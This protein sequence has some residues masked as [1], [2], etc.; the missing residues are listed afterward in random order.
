MPKPFIDRQR[1][2][3]LM[4]KAGIDALLV[5]QPENFAYA[6]GGPPGIA[7]S[8]RR[9]GAAIAIVPAAAGAEPAAIVTDFGEGPF[10]RSAALR[11]VRTHTA[12]VD[13]VDVAAKLP[14]N[15][16]I[17]ELIAEVQP[18]R[19][20]GFHRP[21]TFD[22]RRALEL[23]RDA[24][25]ERGLAKARLGVEFDFLPVSDMRLIESVLPEA[26]LVDS[27]PVFDRLRMVKTPAE[28]DLLRKGA[29]LAEA[30]IRAVMAQIHVG[31]TRAEI[32][33]LWRATVL[34]EARRKGVAN[35]TGQWDYTAVGPDPWSPHGVVEHGSVVKIDVGCVLSGYSSDSARTFCF[36]RASVHAR[37]VYDG[38][39]AAFDAGRS[40]FKPGS[41][42]GDVHAACVAAMRAHGFTTFMRGHFGHGIGQN[43]WSEEWPY[44]GHDVD[45]ALEPGM[46]MAFETPYYVNGVGAFIIEDQLLVTEDGHETMNTLPYEFVEIGT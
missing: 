24:L 30:G 18:E 3:L 41:A 40:V 28:I 44:T 33:E 43:V 20:R 35:L 19:A 26:T 37:S 21:P 8:W 29:Q 22:P 1:A 36:G 13:N 25:A 12:W 23:A 14:S 11:D 5:V 16:P 31:Q 39:R 17:A 6:T 4:A 2:E 45:V 15:R 27:S 32:S 42:L 46:V 38:L 7:A 10:R 9:V 34:A